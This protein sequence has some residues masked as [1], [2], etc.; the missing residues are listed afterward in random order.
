MISIS[1]TVRGQCVLTRARRSRELGKDAAQPARAHAE[2]DAKYADTHHRTVSRR[3]TTFETTRALSRA[4]EKC[5]HDETP[6]RNFSVYCYSKPPTHAV[7]PARHI[8]VLRKREA[9]AGT[10]GGTTA[11]Q[12]PVSPP[13]LRASRHARGERRHSSIP[14]RC[15]SNRCACQGSTKSLRPKPAE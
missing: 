2:H 15:N 5:N 7:T 1:R 12:C 13:R 6:L 10:R 8:T 3:Q 9:P 14:S 4:H 11:L